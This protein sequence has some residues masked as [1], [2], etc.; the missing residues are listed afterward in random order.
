[1][2]TMTKLYGT[3]SN[4]FVV[5]LPYINSTIQCTLCHNIHLNPFG[6]TLQY[7]FTLNDITVRGEFTPHTNKPNSPAILLE[8]Q[9]E[10]ANKLANLLVLQLHD[11]TKD[12]QDGYN[13]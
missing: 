13:N 5:Y 7:I 11:N 2:T 6:P 3:M 8:L 1:M 9:S 4:N 12:I 10:I